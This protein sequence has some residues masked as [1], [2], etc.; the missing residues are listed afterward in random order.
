MLPGAPRAWSPVQIQQVVEGGEGSKLKEMNEQVPVSCH[1]VFLL[2]VMCQCVL[3]VAFGTRAHTWLVYV[4][5]GRILVKGLVCSCV[6]R[7][8]HAECPDRMK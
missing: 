6:W 8:R 1:F 5:F 3:T 7:F 4:G 2:I